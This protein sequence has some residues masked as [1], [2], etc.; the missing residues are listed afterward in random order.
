MIHAY[1]AHSPN[2]PLIPYDYSPEPLHPDEVKI[3]IECCGLCHSDLHLIE[4]EW[5]TQYPLIPGHE[6]IGKIIQ[7]G[8]A[9]KH[10]QIGDRVGISWQCGA[11]LSCPACLSGQETACPSKVRTCVNRPGGFADKIIINYQFVYSIPPELK[12]TTAAP[13]LCAGITVYSPLRT[14]VTAPQSIAIIGIGG[15]GH[16]ALQ[17]GRAF[18]CEVT[19]ISTTPGK[20]K[21]S[22]LFGA[23]HFQ[24]LHDLKPNTP[25]QFDFILSTVHADLN[26][27]LLLGLLKPSGKLCCVGI[28]QTEIK[29]TARQLIS[30]NRSL[31]GSSTGSRF[32]MQEML[33]FAARHNIEAQVEVMPMSKINEAVAK[34]KK[35]E[36]RYRIVLQQN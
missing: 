10:L 11:C 24:L 32:Q 2:T 8:S 5:P 7:T 16:L 30:N 19:A 21:E 4:G 22:K 26:W 15:L 18:G 14:H 23:H 12:S 9:F 28:P 17:F 35:N 25:P 31:C 13:L 34:L 20:E 6:I 33:H 1:A 27:G 36:A 3:Q 29:V